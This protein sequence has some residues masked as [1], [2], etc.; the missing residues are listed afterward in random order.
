MII[1]EA[2]KD[3]LVILQL[4]FSNSNNIYIVLIIMMKSFLF[5]LFINP[6]SFESSILN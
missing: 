5:N 3:M 4:G 2:T 1:L 6:I